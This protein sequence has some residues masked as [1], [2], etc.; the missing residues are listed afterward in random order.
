MHR[1]VPTSP[2]W[3]AGRLL[4]AAVVGLVAVASVV[5]AVAAPADPAA[6]ANEQHEYQIDPAHSGA[7][8]GDIFI[9]PLERKWAVPLPVPCTGNVCTNNQASYPIVAGGRVFVTSQIY[10]TESVVFALDQETGRTLWGPVGV[11]GD[12]LFAAPAYDQ[13]RLFVVVGDVTQV[14]AMALDPATGRRLWS[15]ALTPSASAPPVA[16]NGVLYVTTDTAIHALRASDGGQLWS[17]GVGCC[18]A[19]AVVAGSTV[20]VSASMHNVWAFSTSGALR[21]HFSDGWTA[22][23][24]VPV[25]YRG[26]LYVRGGGTDALGRVFDAATGK[27]LDDLDAIYPPAFSG[28]Y[29]YFLGDKSCAGKIDTVCALRAVDLTT[30]QVAWRFAGDG[31]LNTAP[32]IV[33]GYL[34]TASFSGKVYALEAATGRQVWSTDTGESIPGTTDTGLGAGGGMLFVPTWPNGPVPELRLFAYGARPPAAG[35]YGPVA[36][37]RL[38]DTRTSLGGHLGALGPR[39]SL[40][41]KVAGRGGIPSSGATAVALNLTVAKPTTGGY[42]TAFPSG[43]SRP[44]TSSLNFT[45]GQTLSNTALVPLG[46]DG[47]VTVYNSSGTTHVVVDAQGWFAGGAPAAGGF[48]P[49]APV[50][51]LDTRTGLGGHLGALGPQQALTLQVAGRGGV[52]SSGAA[53]VALNLTVAKP[54]T[55]GYLTAYPAGTS[56]PPTSSLNFT[57]ERTLSNTGL[58]P[59]GADGSV[60]IYNSSGSTHVVVDAQGWFA[61]GAPAAGGYGPV[62]PARLLDTRTSLGG[63]LGALGPQQSL[64]LKVAGQGGIPSSRAAAVA[65]NLTVAKPTTGGYLTAYPAGT[66]RPPTSSLNF[67]AGQTLSNTALVP[68]GADGSVTIYNSS[69]STHVVVDAQGWFRTTN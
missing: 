40:T 29:G 15:R 51:L 28:S 13:G 24:A 20:Y 7:Q 1:R 43:T 14:V 45:A 41:L 61:D 31:S 53:A 12:A 19:G 22:T 35:G 47:S 23:G 69:G 68:L 42:L 11:G 54:T 16:V 30:G 55:G 4:V 3:R 34:Y 48:G 52:P 50:R 18:G 9:P 64:T 44:P 6:V 17:R 49:V 60:T 56:R 57:A 62:A 63:H 36:P 67:T 2:G 59:L 21:W 66:S 25:Y 65:L 26:R 5:P 58:V 46:A 37:A 10:Q 33:N 32:V 27:L 39:Q 8:P 38:L